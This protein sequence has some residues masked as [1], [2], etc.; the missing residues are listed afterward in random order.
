NIV[1]FTN[2]FH[3]VSL[4]AAAATGNQHHRGG[5]GMPLGGV[6]RIPYDGYMGGSLDSVRL[7][8]K[9][10]GDASSGIDAPAAVIVE[11]VQGEGGINVASQ[12]WLKALEATCRRHGMLLIIDDIQAGC[13]RTGTFFSFETFG[14]SP[15]IVTLSKSL[16]GFG[17][18]FAVVL[19][20]PALDQWAPGEHNGTFRGNNHAFI[21]AKAAIDTYWA[22]DTFQ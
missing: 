17:L 4:G 7:L 5:C 2:G 1:A 16:S 11:T 9:M 19:M 12:R 22:D 8:D 6:T 18:P 21:T 14:I 20:K 13:G 3:G 15:D 10:L